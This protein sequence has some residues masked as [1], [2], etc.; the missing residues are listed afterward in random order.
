MVNVM[1]P[2][3]IAR[4]TKSSAAAE[5]TPRQNKI[6]DKA[7]GLIRVEGLAGLTMS[8]VAGLMEFSE[9]AVYR[10]F[11]TKR[12]LVLGIIR[13]LEIVLIEPMQ[14]IAARTDRPVAE[15]IGDILLHHLNLIADYNALPIL[16]FAEASVSPDERLGQAMAEIFCAYENL[17]RSLIREGQQN[18]EINPRL[19]A[20]EGALILIGA[21]AACALRLRLLHDVSQESKRKSLV[22]IIQ[23]EILMPAEVK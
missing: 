7:L 14:A 11:K 2:N 16:L 1:R 19:T 18:G 22:G 3:P 13:R 9:P 17:L 20:E 6:L 12:N 10:H 4:K 8:K 5:F 21:P 23:S 15:R